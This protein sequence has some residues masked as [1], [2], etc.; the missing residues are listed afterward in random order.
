MEEH[1]FDEEMQSLK[2]LI[3]SSQWE[4]GGKV[5]TASSISEELLERFLSRCAR[6][7]CTVTRCSSVGCAVRVYMPLRV[8]DMPLTHC[9]PKSPRMCISAGTVFGTSRPRSRC[10]ATLSG[11][12]RICLSR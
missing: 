8:D 5:V 10:T 6:T 7:R 2:A 3:D 9:S 1:E 12:P 11:Q 4:I